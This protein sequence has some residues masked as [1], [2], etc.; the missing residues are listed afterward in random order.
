MKWKLVPTE[1]THEMTSGV[2]L[3][4]YDRTMAVRVFQSIVD[5][6]PKARED[7]ELVASVAR[8]VCNVGGCGDFDSA[9]SQRFCR[10]EGASRDSCYVTSRAILKMLEE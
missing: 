8:R 6:S 9:E 3:P 10:R 1:V 5:H 4:G 2:V 7:D